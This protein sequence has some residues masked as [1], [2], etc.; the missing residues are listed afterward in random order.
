MMRETPPLYRNGTQ[1]I[2][3]WNSP[4]HKLLTHL[5]QTKVGPLFCIEPSRAPN[6][7]QFAG[8]LAHL[9]MP[10]HVTLPNHAGNYIIMWLDIKLLKFI[11]A[12]ISR[13]CKT[14][15]MWR[16]QENYYMLVVLHAHA[17]EEVS[18]DT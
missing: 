17:R 5:S 13:Y 3:D 1:Q 2:S 8:A 12:C 6:W 14:F 10:C 18:D 15:N 4:L 7:L 11:D 9:M 16:G